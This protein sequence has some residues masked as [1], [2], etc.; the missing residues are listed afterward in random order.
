M[1]AGI[2]DPSGVHIRERNGNCFH[3]IV[4][5][6]TWYMVRHR[7]PVSRPLYNQVL[8]LILIVD[9]LIGLLVDL[10]IDLCTDL[11]A[12]LLLDLLVDLIVALLIARNGNAGLS[13]LYYPGDVGFHTN[14]NSKTAPGLGLFCCSYY[15][16]P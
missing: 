1:M 13:W 2:V 8:I 5:T 15:G 16:G 6:G 14:L 3:I 11:S 7:T 12:D 4:Q 9:L 10:S